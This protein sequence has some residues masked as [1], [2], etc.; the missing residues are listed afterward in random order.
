V[1]IGARI[2]VSNLIIDWTLEWDDRVVFVHALEST[3]REPKFAKVV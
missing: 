1:L 3:K 2:G